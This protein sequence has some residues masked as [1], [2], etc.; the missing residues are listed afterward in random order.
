MLPSCADGVGGV[1]AGGEEHQGVEDV[2]V[3]SGGVLECAVPLLDGAGE[4]AAEVGFEL[5]VAFEVGE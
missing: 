4:P 1:V 2:V 5:D 3:E